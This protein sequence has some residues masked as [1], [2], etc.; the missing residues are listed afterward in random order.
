MIAILDFELFSIQSKCSYLEKKLY[1]H[2]SGRWTESEIA[3][4]NI[5]IYIYIYSLD[6]LC[7]NKKQKMTKR[8]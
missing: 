4:E 5:N 2:N 8:S 3:S 1:L 7:K 6:K